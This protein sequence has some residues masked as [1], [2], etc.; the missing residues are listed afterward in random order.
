MTS[1]K[2]LN[3]HVYWA[4]FKLGDIQQRSSTRSISMTAWPRG[5]YVEIRKFTYWALRC[6]IG[7]APHGQLFQASEVI[8]I[9]IYRRCAGF[10]RVPNIFPYQFW[11]PVLHGSYIPC[12]GRDRRASRTSGNW[13]NFGLQITLPKL[14]YGSPSTARTRRGNPENFRKVMLHRAARKRTKQSVLFLVLL[15]S[16]LR[17]T[18]SW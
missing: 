6:K 16:S 11:V 15:A 13:M 4:L 5:R 2:G 14:R 12:P 8:E 3:F 7:I 10:E 1:E 17:I 9:Y 18:S